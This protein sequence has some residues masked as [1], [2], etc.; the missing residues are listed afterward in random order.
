MAFCEYISGWF[1]RNVFLR[2]LP[3]EFANHILCF[4]IQNKTKRFRVIISF[5][6]DDNEI[7]SL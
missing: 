5:F 2:G 6:L 1:H 4:V 3:L 7:S